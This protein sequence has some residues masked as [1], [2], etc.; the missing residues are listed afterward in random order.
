MEMGMGTTTTTK[1]ADELCQ[2]QGRAAHFMAANLRRRLYKLM[3]CHTVPG[4]SRSRCTIS[5]RP[6]D[7]VTLR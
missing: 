4:R 7:L 5:E 3:Q 6:A 1:G 2:I